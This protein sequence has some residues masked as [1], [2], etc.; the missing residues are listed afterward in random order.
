MCHPVLAGG[1]LFT[2]LGMGWAL[3]PSSLLQIDGFEDGVGRRGGVCFPG[4]NPTRLSSIVSR[5]HP[6]AKTD[7]WLKKE[8]V[9]E[10][11]AHRARVFCGPS[12]RMRM[13]R[14]PTLH[15]HFGLG[16]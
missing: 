8:M 14:V 5:G 7:G 6:A 3:F 1:P 10:N 12:R 2:R 4:P 9:T 13:K 15:F 16:V 11:N